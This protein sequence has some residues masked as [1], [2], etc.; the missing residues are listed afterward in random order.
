MAPVTGGKFRTY[1]VIEFPVSFAYKA[2]LD[3]IQNNDVIQKKLPKLKDTAAF[4]ELEQYVAD[5]AA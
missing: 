1:I 2:Y 5:F 3:N 4:K